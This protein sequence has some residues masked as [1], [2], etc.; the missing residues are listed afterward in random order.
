[1]SDSSAPDRL[2]G[3]DLTTWAALATVLEWL[4]PALDAPLAHG[5]DLTHFEYGILFALADAPD[6]ALRMTVLASYSNSSL[7]RLSRAV[8][9]IE[10]RGLVQRT[11]DPLD[12]RSTLA[13]LTQTGVE[14]LDKATPVQAQTVTKLVLEPLTKAQRSQLREICLRI[15]RA[16]REQE[17]WQPPRSVPP[18]TA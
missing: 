8:S 17:G 7:S 3:D 12:G 6:H 5:F 9:R 13:T 10:G 18:D 15:Q 2:A 14:L 1:M 11:P 4:P 16:I